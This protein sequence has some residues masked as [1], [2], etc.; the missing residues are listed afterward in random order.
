MG[1]LF[2]NFVRHDGTRGSAILLK[3]HHCMGDGYSFASTFM[4]GVEKV[5]LPDPK[6][7]QSLAERA[8]QPGQV[9][10]FFGA[11]SKLLTAK[12]DPPSALKAKNLLKASGERHAVWI[13]AKATIE[14]IKRASKTH[15]F[16]LNDAVLGALSAALRQYLISKGKTPA[17][18]LSVIWV[19]LRPIG[20]AFEVKDP[21]EVESPGNRTL[22]AVLLKLPV[23]QESSSLDRARTIASLV[24]DMKGSPEPLLA[25]KITGLFGL[26][27]RQLSDPIWNSLSNKVS[28][29]VSNVPGP[30]FPMKWSGVQIKNAQ[31]WVPPVG[32][33]STFA[34]ITSVENNISLSLG[35]DAAVFSK[36]DAGFITRA[37]DEELSAITSAS[38][39]S[40][41]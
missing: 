27:P 2:Q 14:E 38:P 7:A 17:D 21:S 30:K 31:V 11:A 37:F 9:G 10:K 40:R 41:L 39:A 20:G 15:G 6:P 22:G 8:H 19:A 3:F 25:Q 13:S 36:D 4:T 18:P 24:H 16:T 28:I 35:M 33:I 32:T 5:P 23:S 34:L 12:D 26:L 29:S 1:T